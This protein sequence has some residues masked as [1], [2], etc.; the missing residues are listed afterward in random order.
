MPPRSRPEVVCPPDH[1][2][3]ANSTCRSLHGCA[4]DGC[5]AGAAATQRRLYWARKT[6]CA[7]LVPAL[8]AQ[9]RIRALQRLGWSAKAIAERVDRTE[10]WVG[11]ILRNERI[12]PA[13]HRI[14]DR[15]FRDL[16]F[17]LPNPTGR[18][19]KAAVTKARRY[20]E[21]AGWAPPL[22]WDNIDDPNETPQGYRK[23]A[24]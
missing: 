3:G 20:A 15:L 13:T 23:E 14:I 12:T 11:A 21:R 16:Q 6:G 24:A 5:R 9:R 2:H 22:A 10:S 7:R 19:E 8:G 17:T 18:H 1:A 4:C